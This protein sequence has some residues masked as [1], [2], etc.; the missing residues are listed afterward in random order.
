MKIAQGVAH[1]QTVV[2][3]TPFSTMK[4]RT[5][6]SNVIYALAETGSPCVLSFVR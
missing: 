5:D 6:I 2:P 4:S 3:M 1:V